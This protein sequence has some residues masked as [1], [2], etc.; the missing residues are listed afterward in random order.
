MVD[1]VVKPPERSHDDLDLL[2]EPKSTL[3]LSASTSM[4]NLAD[5]DAVVVPDVQFW[6]DLDL[7]FDSFDM[8]GFHEQ[9]PQK[10]RHIVPQSAAVVS[11]KIQFLTFLSYSF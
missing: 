8:F 1:P 10:V 3:T 6:Q 5:L 4:P 7:R 9:S 2:F 11:F